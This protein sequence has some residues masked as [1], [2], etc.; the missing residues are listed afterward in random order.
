MFTMEDLQA[1]QVVSSEIFS[2]ERSRVAYEL[3]LMTG[4]ERGV[5][6]ERMV[7]NR[8]LADG[9]DVK[10][11]G[12][13]NSYDMQIVH[14]NTI[15][16]IEVKL[17][18]YAQKAKTKKGVTYGYNFQKIK[19]YFFNF[20]FFVFLTPDGLLV[21]W[22]KSEDVADYCFCK[23]EGASGYNIGANSNREIIKTHGILT[24]NDY[25]DFS[26]EVM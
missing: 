26:G 7:Y 23:K 12:G 25:N 20:L 19:P 13:T 15:Y 8:L 4:P 6:A 3:S 21:K 11:I 9:W 18:T 16:K 10:Y 14:N 24:L 17:A 5:C 1:T 22:A 2:P